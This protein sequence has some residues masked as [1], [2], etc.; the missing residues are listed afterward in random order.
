MQTYKTEVLHTLYM[1]MYLNLLLLCT[2]YIDSGTEWPTSACHVSR[3]VEGNLVDWI[4]H[5]GLGNQ[6]LVN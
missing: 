1:K 4:K 3:N 2:F 5:G 6:Y